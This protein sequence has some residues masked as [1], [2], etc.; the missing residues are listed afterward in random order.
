MENRPRTG[1]SI[2]SSASSY[3]SRRISRNNTRE[4]R[5]KYALSR[6]PL[7]TYFENNDAIVYPKFVPSSPPSGENTQGI[8]SPGR[9]RPSFQ[10]RVS[11]ILKR[12]V[13]LFAGISSVDCR[14]DSSL[15]ERNGKC[16][17]P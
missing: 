5:E 3:V 2:N 4:R 12:T 14:R 10:P 15:T 11:T 8:S 16:V 6:R 1:R 13:G 9:L 7:N 17:Y